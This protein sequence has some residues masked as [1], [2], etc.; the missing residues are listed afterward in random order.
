[1]RSIAILIVIVLG[2][3]GAL[4]SRHVGLLTYVWFSLFRPVEWVWWDLSSLRLSLVAGIVFLIPSLATGVFPNFSH[5]LSIMSWLFMGLVL[6]AQFTTYIPTD[7]SWVDQFARLLIVSGLGVTLLT[8]K[9]RLSQLVAVMAGS[10]AFYS[11]KAG[12]VSLMGGGVQ[13]SEGQAGAFVDNN[14]YALAVNMA[15]PLMAA[16]AATLYVPFPGIK[17][18]RQGF[19]IAIPLSVITVIGTMSRAGLLALGAL[20][21]ALAL[22]QRR[23]LLW[24]SGIAITGLLI[25]N[26]APMPEGYLDRMNTIQTY[27]QVGEM[28]ALG[29][30]HFW[31]IALVMVEDNPLGVGLRNYDAAY[32]DY[33]DSGGAFGSGRSVHNS[34]LQ[35]LA[36]E[37]YLGFLLWL[38]MFAYAIATCLRIRFAATALQGLSAENRTFYVSMATAFAASMFAFMVGG[39]F[40]ASANNEVT[41]LTFGVTAAL[42]RMYKAEALAL[43]PAR[44]ETDRAVPVLP[45][46]RRKAIA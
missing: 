39:S 19:L 6:I 38:V 9:E 22:L 4:I 25:F 7:W 43:Q 17:Y 18:I 14:G 10:F 2:L 40:I 12:L 15:I 8:T 31:R 33:D 37:G 30:L 1:M 28:S 23:P 34:H 26:F 16:S 29:R 20:A 41:W 13:F 27:D 24:T 46:P 3:G 11:A 45:R 5:P 32:D 35:V 42:H 21:I 36:E 44:V